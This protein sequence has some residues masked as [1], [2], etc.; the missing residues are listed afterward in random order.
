MEYS[1]AIVHDLIGVWFYRFGLVFSSDGA[2]PGIDQ[3]LHFC[4]ILDFA[5]QVLLHHEG[6]NRRRPSTAKTS[7][8]AFNRVNSQLVNCCGAN[9]A[10]QT[11]N[12]TGTM[13]LKFPF[14]V[15]KTT[16]NVWDDTLG[17]TIP[18][19]FVGEE[20]LFG[21]TVYKF[22]ATEAADG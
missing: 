6:A 12:F 4:R 8:Y 2:K 20:Q 21:H 1:V 15:Q 10:D 5:F 11:V 14:N 9:V 3:W 19:E 16:Q 17:T 7:R 13:P 18:Y 22:Q